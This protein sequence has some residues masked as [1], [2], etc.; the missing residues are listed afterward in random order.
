MNKITLKTIALLVLLIPVFSLADTVTLV[1]TN[2]FTTLGVTTTYYTGLKKPGFWS[3]E[4]N[5]LSS[6]IAYWQNKFTAWGNTQAVGYSKMM[7]SNLENTIIRT[8]DY[9]VSVENLANST[10]LALNQKTDMQNHLGLAQIAIEKAENNLVIIAARNNTSRPP[11]GAISFNQLK[12]IVKDTVDDI[13]LANKE[14]GLAHDIIK[15][16]RN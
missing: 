11:K 6:R 12:Q 10:S 3:R 8:E 7:G 16:A 14:I 9:F 5:F 2:S 4:K 15:D 1:P 13:R